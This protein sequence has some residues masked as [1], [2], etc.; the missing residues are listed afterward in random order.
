[1]IACL[2]SF[3]AIVG[4]GSASCFIEYNPGRH[5]VQRNDPDL[6]GHRQWLVVVPEGLEPNAPAVIFLHGIGSTPYWADA[7]LNFSAALQARRWTGILPFG[8]GI[9]NQEGANACCDAG[10][11]AECCEDP[12]TTG[13]DGNRTCGWDVTGHP[14]SGGD[15]GK[16]LDVEFLKY[17]TWWSAAY[18][19]TDPAHIFL[20]GLGA[21]AMMGNRVACEAAAVFAGVGL[22]AG[23][24]MTP[25]VNPSKPV[26]FL[27]IDGTKDPTYHY[28]GI[29]TSFYRNI[30]SW[31]SRNGCHLVP[32]TNVSDEAS[33]QRS[34]ELSSSKILSTI[35]SSCM[36]FHECVASTR[37]CLVDGL[38][39]HWA[40]HVE[41]GCPGASWCASRGVLPGDI[42]ATQQIFELFEEIVS[43]PKTAWIT[44]FAVRVRLAWGNLVFRSDD[45][46]AYFD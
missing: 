34:V 44:A 35:T 26:A 32:A 29:Q 17:L 36:E 8:T 39:H 1:M 6:G 45:F 7:M 15:L 19:C 12:L 11:D 22:Q 10:C 5:L 3:S 23:N 20:A 38:E 41:P 42:D 16:P 18:V 43:R 33:A 28:P 2:L 27:E 30:H 9:V 37:Y 25:C 13:A 24:A 46:M 31:A 40:G 21:G 4:I 14:G